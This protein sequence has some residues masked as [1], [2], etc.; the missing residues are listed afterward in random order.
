MMINAH[1]KTS[2][3][4][5]EKLGKF[6]E[7]LVKMDAEVGVEGDADRAVDTGVKATRENML[8]QHNMEN[9]SKEDSLKARAKIEAE[10]RL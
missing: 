8:R 7:A 10:M 4:F 1:H 6:G 2:E 9:V 3:N 5:D